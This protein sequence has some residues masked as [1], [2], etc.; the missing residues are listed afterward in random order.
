[1][2]KLLPI[3]LGI[4]CTV[5]TFIGCEDDPER[6]LVVEYPSLSYAPMHLG[7]EWKYYSSRQ[8]DT[9]LLWIDGATL[10][11]KAV[12]YNVRQAWV[13]SI[14]GMTT[15]YIRSDGTGKMYEWK[16]SADVLFFDYT[17]DTVSANEYN[18]EVANGIADSIRVIAGLFLKTKST[19]SPN[20][21][22][23][24]VKVEYAEGVGMVRKISLDSQSVPR[25]DTLS[26]SYAYINKKDY[27]KR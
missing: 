24:L 26:L 2:N 11:G 4:V 1:M 6:P 10:L 16:D 20:A 3:V 7:D 17:R 5:L 14:P 18:V 19:I 23:G 15:R 8:K 21:L 13:A 27:G 25:L 22:L 9:L 12:Y